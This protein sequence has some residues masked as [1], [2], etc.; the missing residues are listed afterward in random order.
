MKMPDQSA[1]AWAKCGG[2]V[3]VVWCA[4]RHRHG[5]GSVSLEPAAARPTCTT[6]PADTSEH[7][8]E[9]APCSDQASSTL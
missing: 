7:H 8:V 6:A 4:G 5:T 2:L 1:G 3:E 9:A